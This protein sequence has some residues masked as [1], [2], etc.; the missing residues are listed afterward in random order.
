MQT[1]ILTKNNC[2]EVLI[3]VEFQLQK[4]DSNQFFFHCLTGKLGIRFHIHFF[5]DAGS[6]SAYCSSAQG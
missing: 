4:D 5:Y 2:S 3:F 1:T 6:V